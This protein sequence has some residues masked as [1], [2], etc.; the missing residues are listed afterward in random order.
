M[1]GYT[2]MRL[3]HVHTVLL[4]YFRQAQG[5]AG[6]A[7]QHGG[8][9]FLHGAQPLQ[10]VHAATRNGERTNTFG[11]LVS[12]PEADKGAEAKGQEKNIVASDSGRTIDCCPASGP[13]VPALLRIQYLQGLPGRAGGLMEADVITQG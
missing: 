1:N 4:R 8:P 13:P 12:G 6:R 11:S 2:H 3:A 7:D 5:V 9:D 10:R